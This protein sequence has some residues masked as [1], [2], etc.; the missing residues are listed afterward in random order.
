MSVISLSKNYTGFDPRTI[1]GCQLW[2]DGADSSSLTLSGSS[3]T[4][5]RDKSGNNFHASQSTT[6]KQGTIVSTGGVRMTTSAWYNLNGTTGATYTKTHSVFIVATPSTSAGYFY[7]RNPANGGGPTIIS[8]FTGTSIEYYDSSQRYTFSSAPTASTPFIACYTRTQGG[9]IVGSFNGS[10]VFTQAQTYDN[11]TTYGW[12]YLNA[13]M[14]DTYTDRTNSTVYEFIIYNEALTTSQRQLIEGYL[15]WKWGRVSSLPGTHPYKRTPLFTRPFQPTDI[16]GCSL[17]LD[18]ADASSLT[19]SGSSVTQWNDKSGSSIFFTNSGTITQSSISGNPTVFFSGGAGMT[20]SA[21]ISLVSGSHTIF[22]AF[23]P[24]LVSGAGMAYLISDGNSDFGI[25]FDGNYTIRLSTGPADW[26]GGTGTN[27]AVINSTPVSTSNPGII[28]SMN[29]LYSTFNQTNRSASIRLSG[30]FN[31][32]FYTGHICEV[33][34]YSSVPSANDCR[35]IE[36]YLANKWVLRSNLPSTHPF[37]LF[38]PLTTLFNP[39]QISGCTAWFDGLDPSGNGS[40]PVNGASLA[41]W[42]DKS[43]NGRN[44]SGGVS[45]TYT[46]G[47][48]VTFNGTSQYYTMSIPYSG[49]YSIFLVATNTTVPQCYFFGRDAMGGARFSTFI[50][51]YIGAG[52]GLEWWELNDRATIATTPSSPFIASVD[53]T[54]GSNIT[55]YYFGTQSFSRSQTQAYNSAAWDTLGQAGA[56]AGVNF[57]GGTMKELIFFGNVI[58]ASQRQQVEGYLASKWGLKNGL[59]S[60]H[61]FKRITP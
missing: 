44:A 26:G 35:R 48:G 55:G 21:A 28:N 23:Y 41:T 8:A 39:L 52:I 18:A 31:S 36:G 57:Y 19:L 40:T 15:A 4:A 46:V 7:G 20:I 30:S 58:T 10:V 1:P 37:K 42:V 2:L 34:L 43:G 47:G 5:W 61:P 12:L 29:V 59:P 51:G 11:G 45:P 24:T 14:G 54:Q 56:S 13:S 33:I 9:N 49:N 53:H 3:V 25:R 16:L 22:I 17:W 6:A 38:P 60:T 27:N 32:R 50:Q